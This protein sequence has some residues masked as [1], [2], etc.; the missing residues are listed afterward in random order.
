MT[1]PTHRLRRL[2]RTEGIRRLVSEA[3]LSPDR[4][5]LPIFA[6][7]DIVEEEPLAALPGHFHWPPSRIGVIAKEAAAA[8]I[9]GLLIFGVTS[10]KDDRASRASAKDGPAQV[11]I[12][13]AKSAAPELVVFADTCLCGYTSHGHCGIVDGGEVAND[14]TVEVLADVAVSQAE[15]GADFVSPSDMMDG[16]VAAIRQAL[17]ESGRAAAGI[18]AYSAKF[19]SAMYG[20]FRDAA[21]CTPQFGDRRGYQIDPPDRRQGLA[22]LERDIDEGADIVMVK[23][24]LPYL[25]VIHAARERIEAPLAAYNVS[26]EFAMVKAAAERGWMDDRTAALEVLTAIVRAGADFIL[27][28][29]ALEAARWLEES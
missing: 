9:P 25:D 18:M 8:G 3:R 19:A 10:N 1:T 24:A 12:G 7:E 5:V 29:H 23:P 14:A 6:S 20:P 15:A 13:E 17:D 11:A 16:R 4:F 28:Y 26:G 22:S 2:R 21:D 27:T